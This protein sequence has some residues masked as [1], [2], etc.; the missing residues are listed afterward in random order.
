MASCAPIRAFAA[1]PGQRRAVQRLFLYVL[2]APAFLGDHLGLGPT[3]FF[4]LFLLTIAGIMGG[5]WVSGRAGRIAPKRQIRH[6]LLIM[7][8]VSIANVVANLL[9][10][11]HVGWALL[12]V[13]IYAF[14]WSLM[15]P[16]VTLLVLDLYPLRRGLAS[17]LQ[18]VVGST[19]NG[20]VA[21]VLAPLV[22]H[23]TA[24]LALGSGRADGHRASWIYLHHRWPEIGRTAA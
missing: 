7:T 2:S 20:L 5:A 3:Q 11:A 19:A 21:G 22:M 15:V 17:S 10:P 14:G 6:G 13:G 9:L 4:W 24:A 1:G 12:P 18:A 23:S 16:V 8:V